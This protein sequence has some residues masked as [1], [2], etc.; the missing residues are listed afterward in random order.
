MKEIN[1]AEILTAKRHEKGITQDE[2][3]A[4]MGVSKASVSKW[5]TG[6]NLPDIT[7]LPI[8]ASYFDISIDALIGYA[9]QL[10]KDEIDNIYSKLSSSFAK[11]TFEDVIIESQTYIKK[12]YSCYPFLLEMSNFYINHSML[13]PNLE[14][15]NKLLKAA[16]QLCDRVKSLCQDTSLA[17]KAGL[18]QAMCF[19]SLGEAEQVL[20]TLGETVQIHINGSTFIWQAHQALGKHEKA[21]EVIQADLY[22]NLMEVF[23]G[24]IAYIQINL[25]SYDIAIK[26]YKRAED[27]AE[28]FEMR[29]LNPNN[30]ALLYICGAQ[31][32]QTVDKHKE[33][34]EILSKYVDLCIYDFFPFEPKGNAFFDRIDGW[35]KSNSG[36]MPRSNIIVKESMLNDVLLSPVFDKL[37]AYP[38]YN[39]LIYKLR[40]FIG[41]K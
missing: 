25:G 3:A 21:K 10:S 28:I 38:E 7:L 23:L 20:Q 18:L 30:M 4:Y 1:I 39:K 6:V 17:N 27:F 32:Y 8:L 36:A 37:K 12:Y 13:A 31:I 24:L 22:Q 34:I 5:E 16:L 26:A 2:L 14:S 9:P 29:Q 41:G 40:N 35:L 33:A 15:R 11:L 19:L